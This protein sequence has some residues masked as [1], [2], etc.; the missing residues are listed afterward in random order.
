MIRESDRLD[1]EKKV[2]VAELLRI[3]EDLPIEIAVYDL[4]GIYK[5]VNN[6]YDVDEELRRS[7]IGRDDIFY[8]NKKGI[9][10]FCAEK[11]S[12][13]FAQAIRERRTVKFTEKLLI[14]NDNRTLYYRRT[15]RP[16]DLLNEGDI[17]HVFSF[18]SSLNTAVL[19]QKELRYLAY[20]DKLTGLKN[21]AAFYE[22]LQQILKESSR[23]V[24][25]HVTAILICNIDN[26]KLVNESLGYDIGDLLLQEVASRLKISV[27]KTDSVYRFG[28][29]EFAVILKDISQEYDAG[30]IAEKFTKYISKPY[31]IKDQRINFVTSSVGIVL[32]PK[33]GQ[34]I[35]ALLK[36]VDTALYSAKKRGKNN[37]Q[38]FS[39]AM[40]EYSVKRLKIERNL[41][42]L[43]NNNDYDNQFKIRYQPI[44]EKTLTGDYK[45]IGSEALLRWENKELGIVN[46]DIFIPVAEEANLI[47]DIGSWSFRKSL[48]EYR[49]INSNRDFPLYLSINFSARQLRSKEA[50][51]RL[52]KILIEEKFDPEYLQLEL[53]ETSY[54]HDDATVVENLREIDDMGIMLALDDFGVGFASLSYLHKVPAHTIKIDRSFIKYLSTSDHHRELVR[55]IIMLGE[56]LNKDVVA[57]GVE[58]VEDLYL[59]DSHRC[60][61]YQGYLFSQPVTIEEF[62]VLTEKENLLTTL[63]A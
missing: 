24:H 59:L 38:F 27:R 50:L 6:K 3:F 11:R 31:V 29:D 33:D 39:K 17:S 52:Q 58:Q 5:F 44:V 25:P 57:E 41:T 56:N 26:F 28:G 47:S 51:K 53:T 45:V 54:L 30:R 12:E 37:Y 48:R 63:I 7:I 10:K 46:P 42:E 60:Y 19:G 62:K 18:G 55:S 14:P 36:N 35:E 20:H 2:A 13:Y 21:R 34:R 4:K 40:T 9:S 22:H 49:H 15:F 61:K 16:V 43:I 1:V 32:F 23:I 8:F